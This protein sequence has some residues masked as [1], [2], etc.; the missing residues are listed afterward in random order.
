MMLSSLVV[1]FMGLAK[2]RRPQAIRFLLL[3]KN[4]LASESS[5]RSS[6]LIHGG[7]RYLESAQLSVE[8][9]LSADSGHNQVKY[10]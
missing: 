2:H 5:S 8:R 6:K 7:L 3:K 9:P 4:A 10:G 1:A